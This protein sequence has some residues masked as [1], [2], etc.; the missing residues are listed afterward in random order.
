MT[1]FS[2]NLCQDRM[3]EISSAI[4]E[5]LLDV[6]R[7]KPVT[8]DGSDWL[9]NYFGSIKGKDEEKIYIEMYEQSYVSFREKYKNQHFDIFFRFNRLS[10]RMQHF[11]LD[12]IRD[13]GMYNL[14]INNPAYDSNGKIDTGCMFGDAILR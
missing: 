2:S 4:E 14:L 9:E 12:F 6:L 11:A 10:F 13:H 7:L 1:L 3:S 8:E 5:N